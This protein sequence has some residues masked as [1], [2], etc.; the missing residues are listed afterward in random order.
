MNFIIP[1]DFIDVS[2]MAAALVMK[3]AVHFADDTRRQNAPGSAHHDTETILLRGPL[4]EV[5]R[6]TWYEDVPHADTELLAGWPSARNVL[7][8]IAESHRRRAGL[9]PVFGKA[10]VVSLKA[11]GH[12]DWHVDEGAYAEAHDRFHVCLIPS[13]GAMMYSG[14][15]GLTLPVGQLTWINNR[16]LHS[17]IN[18]GF[19]PRVHLIVDVRKPETVN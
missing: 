18:V 16:V 6:K 4:G 7:A 17:A 11:G 12:V 10:M 15:L 2:H 8:K 9:E 19:N 13:A 5:S 1:V 14:G 3:H